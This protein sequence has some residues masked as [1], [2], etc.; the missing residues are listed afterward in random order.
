MVIDEEEDFFE[1]EELYYKYEE[2]LPIALE[3]EQNQ[4]EVATF[5]LT[6][7]KLEVKRANK[8]YQTVHQEN[9]YFI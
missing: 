7:Q 5:I 1:E 9:I 8:V 6:N 2:K 3:P 4:Y